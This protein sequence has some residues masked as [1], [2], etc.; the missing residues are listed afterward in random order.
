MN[1]VP[2]RVDLDEVAHLVEQLERDLSRVRA[3]GA[4]VDTLRAEVEQLREALAAADT[5]HHG[6]VHQGLHGVRERLSA[7]SDELV[8]DALKGSDYIAR[9]ARILGLG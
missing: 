6:D 2:P 7:V 1:A 8:G 3:G 9:I 4:S 5:S